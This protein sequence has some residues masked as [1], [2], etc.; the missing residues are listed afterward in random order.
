MPHPTGRDVI[1]IGASAGGVD[2]LKRLLAAVPADLPAAVFIVLHTADHAPGMLAQVLS[3]SSRLPVVTAEEEQRF[4]R[5]QVYV[6][7]SDRHLLVGRDHLHVRRGPRENG[8][9]PAIDPLFRSAAVSCSTRVIGVVLTGLLNDGS[10]G[11]RAIKRCGGVAVVQDP[12]DA[13]YGEMPQNAIRHADIDHVLALDEIPGLLVARAR[14]PRPPRAE[15]AE[16]IRAEALIAAQEVRHLEPS[17]SGILSPI[18][19]PDCHGAMHE[20]REG[21]LVRYRCHTGH[22]FTLQA[23][24]VVQREAWERALYG[25]LRAQQERAALV[26]RLA[27]EAEDKGEALAAQLQRRAETYQEGADLLRRLIGDER[28]SGQGE[29]S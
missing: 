16:D 28:T 17:A 14:E 1:V 5:G 7:P 22:A 11:L 20:I 24:G 15:I 18:T 2:A 13:A 4:A 8:S 12:R 29:V 26:R 27:Q 10:S 3:S 25:A 23:L 6:A 19:C 21:D 9:R